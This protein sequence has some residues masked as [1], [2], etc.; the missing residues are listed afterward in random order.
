MPTIETRSWSLNLPNEWEFEADETCITAWQPISV[1]ALQ[2]ST[3]RKDGLVTDDELRE[4][5]ENNSNLGG[6]LKDVILGDFSGYE[7]CFEDQESSWRH[8]HLRSDNIMI[9]ITYN[10]GVADAGADDAAV[11]AVLAGLR[12][13]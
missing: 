3:Y 1:G 13:R 5:V 4:F 2:F 11:D 6:P 7:I 8:W 10:C 12:R 9:F